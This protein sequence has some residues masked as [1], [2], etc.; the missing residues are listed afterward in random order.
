[1]STRPRDA[2]R[3]VIRDDRDRTERIRWDGDERAQQ[4]E[5]PPPTAPLAVWV[6]RSRFIVLLAVIGVL[7]VSAALFIVGTGLAVQGVWHALVTFARGEFSE[8]MVT[9]DLLEVV[10]VMLKAVVFYLI[11]VGFYSLFIAPLNLTAALGIRSFNDLEIKIVSVI[12]V[13]MAITFLEHF[14]RWDQAVE[15]LMYGVTLALVVGALVFFQKH[16]H[17]ESRDD[18]QED[19]QMRLRAQ[20]R[21][22]HQNEEQR[23]V[24]PDEAPDPAE[25]DGDSRE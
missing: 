5:H 19:A 16:S 17:S 21:L 18:E 11:G 9:V 6:G 2:D 8:A 23:V 24:S 7:L 4:A 15:T 3:N 22:F 10:S 14:I 12:V 1:M 25:H 20:R 13:I